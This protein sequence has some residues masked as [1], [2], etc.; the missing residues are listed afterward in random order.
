MA[1][2]RWFAEDGLRLRVSSSH[3]VKAVMVARL[4]TSKLTSASFICRVSVR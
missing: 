4:M 2:S 3:V 1:A